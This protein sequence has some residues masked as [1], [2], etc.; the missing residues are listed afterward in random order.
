MLGLARALRQLGVDVRVVAPCDGPPPEPGVISRRSERRVGAERLD[1]AD[2]AGPRRA[3]ARTLEALRRF[4]PDVVHLHEPPVPGPSSSA[5]LGFDGPMVGTFHASRRAGCTSGRRAAAVADRMVRRLTVRAAV[6]ESARETARRDSAATYDVLWNGI[7]VDRFATRDPTPSERPAVFFVGRHEPRKGLAVLLDAWR[8]L[9]RDAV[10]WVAATG[11]QTDGAARAAMSRT[12]SGSAGISDDREARRSACA[13]RRCSVRRRWSGESFGVV[14]LEAMA[15]GTA[16]R[17]VRDRGYANVARPRSGG[18]C[19]CA[20]GDV[21]ALRDALRR[22]LDDAGA[23]RRDLVRR[24]GRA[25]RSSRWPASPSAT[26]SS[27]SARSSPRAPAPAMARPLRVARR[28]STPGSRAS[29]S[30]P[31]S[32]GPSRPS[33]GDPA[34]PRGVGVAPGGDATMAIDEIAEHVRGALPRSAPATSRFYSEDRGY[35]R[36]RHAPAR[37]SSSTRS[38]AP[39]PR[40]PASSRA[41]SRSRSCRRRV[42]ATLGDVH[43]RCRARDQERRPL[44]RDA[45]RGR[46]CERA[47]GTAD[48]A[49]AVANTDLAR[50]VL[51]RRAAGPAVLPM[52]DRARGADRRLV[53]ARRLLRSRLGD[54]QHDADRHRPARRVRR[55][56]T[57]ASSTS[58]PSSKP[59]FR[60]RR[61]GRRLHELPLRRRRAGAHRRR[62]RAASSPWPT[63][64]R[65]HDHPAVGSGDG[66][67]LAV[68]GAARPRRST[69]RLA[70]ARSTAG[71]AQPA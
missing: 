26:S 4:E 68:A 43:V 29:T 30:R 6:S 2:R 67:G 11:P 14:L 34:R 53:D 45:R 58:C 9:D 20:P 42:D 61:R 19:S 40:P 47:D 63:A 59:A 69:T 50:A 16:D 36:V 49:R 60:A 52:A 38:T 10:L 17:R 5:L 13:A 70:R 3:R 41:A 18:A 64:P 46:A 48:T 37:S 55:R 28:C 21:D 62:R 32:H 23:A 66:F 56:R 22:V 31:R 27:T 57:A 71:M 65:S 51:D 39:G 44:L 15:A 35:V 7:E 12:S 24:G 8:D 54:V 33:L 1:R 25:P